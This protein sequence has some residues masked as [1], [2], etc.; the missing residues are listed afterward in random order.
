MTVK[1]RVFKKTDRKREE[2]EQISENCG[3]HKWLFWL[4]FS[5]NR[6]F[7]GYFCHDFRQR[8]SHILPQNN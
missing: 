7:S 5:Q 3:L 4:W 1:S 8:D 2:K 6:L